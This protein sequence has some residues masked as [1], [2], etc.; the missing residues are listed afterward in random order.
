M[1]GIVVVGSQWGDEGKGKITNF[2]A[3]DADVIVRY[4]GGDN[5]GHTIVF[6]NQK[7]ELRSVPSGIFDINKLAVIGNGTVLNPK[8][9]LEELAYLRSRGVETTNLKISDRAQVLFSYHK[10]FDILQE[11]AKKENKIGTTGNGIGPAYADKMARTGI[12][13]CDLLD[14]EV[15]E[16]RIKTVVANKNELLTKI[17]NHAPLDADALLE[18]YYAYGQQLAP[19]V[20]D[21]AYLVDEAFKANK[22]VL[23]EGAQGVMLDIDHGTYPYVTSS[24]P[25]AGGVTTGVGIGPNKVTEVVGVSKAYTSRVGEGPFP[26]ELVN[27]IGDHIREVGHEYGVVTHRPR[28]IGWFDS[29]VM[30]HSARVAGITKL[31]VNC[32]DVLTGIEVL[33]IATAYELDGKEIKYY[34]ASFKDLERV[35]PIYEELPGWNEDITNIKRREDLPIN[36]QNYLKRIEALIGV[37]IATFSVGPDRQQTNVLQD[38]WTGEQ[39]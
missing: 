1:A 29:V 21:T 32:I 20:T 13:M 28:R 11:T 4:Q 7:F 19:Y 39:L 3:Q 26:T 34:P 10:L 6:N 9:L 33:K 27:E 17:Y 2:L 5:A 16:Q 12:R 37:E 15:L 25:I 31:A 18:E 23:F 8:S 38:V 14:Y 24:N 22:R 35:T 36:A 30:R